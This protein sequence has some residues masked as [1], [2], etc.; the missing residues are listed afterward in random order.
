MA[1][2]TLVCVEL[3]NPTLVCVG[4]WTHTYSLLSAT[5]FYRN[6]FLFREDG[7]VLPTPYPRMPFAPVVLD[8]LARL[9][10]FAEFATLASGCQRMFA[11]SSEVFAGG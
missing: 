9:V 6:F 11:G 4:F 8:S 1:N 5:T 3:A 10:N 7:A 2:L